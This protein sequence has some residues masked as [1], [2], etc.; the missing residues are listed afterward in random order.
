MYLSVSGSSWE[1]H[2]IRETYYIRVSE[3]LDQIYSDVDFLPFK[4]TMHQKSQRFE[5][6]WLTQL[7]VSK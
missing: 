2:Y 1:R 5:D 7:K 6:H 3:L 4:I